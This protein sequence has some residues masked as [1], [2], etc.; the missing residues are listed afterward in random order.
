M[1][2]CAVRLLPSLVLSLVPCLCGG[3][4]AGE[5]AGAEVTLVTLEGEEQRHR[6]TGLSETELQLELGAVSLKDITAVAF[7]PRPAPGAGATAV[8][9]RN[10]DVLCNAVIAA[11]DESKLTLKAETLGELKLDYKHLQAIAFAGKER[12]PGDA[13]EAFLKAP[14]PKE[15]QLLTAK[16]ETISG[17]LE[18]FAG[19]ELSFNSGGQSRAYLFEQLAAFR[20]A[21]LEEYKPRAELRGTIELRDGSRVTGRL[22]DLKDGKL[23]FE[24]LNGQN[25][26][27]AVET[28]SNITFKGGKL[29]YLSE[30][31]P[32]AIEEKPYVGGMPL[33]YRWQ[34]DRSVTGGKLA[35]GAKTYERGL[36][37]HSFC[38]LGYN[39][40]GQYAKFLCEVGLDDAAAGG[41]CD[42]K[43]LLDG[44][45]AVA[46]T[47]KPGSK[48]EAVRLDLK[49]V[50]QLALICD[51][52]PDD[53]DAGDCLDWGG[54][55]L[56][57]P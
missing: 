57:K 12:P 53:N 26:E 48:A 15:D 22:L 38:R 43:V 18:K 14:P 6:L 31:T 28:L 21:P 56:A 40:A 7:A 9:L 32:S 49:G 8:H 51:Y 13:L 16:G 23:R 24:A 4:A 54:A 37:V 47:A 2:T 5:T 46:G 11:G 34:R 17:Y 42:W 30:L 20:F 44:K 45:E 33:V 27:L 41:I 50:Q 39:L 55:R 36:G 35:V 19:K 10:G 25:W 29:A 3:L 1:V 52:G